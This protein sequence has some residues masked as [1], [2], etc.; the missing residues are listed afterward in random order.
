MENKSNKTF[1]LS[2]WAIKNSTI[3]Y[4]LMGIF[5]ILGGSAYINMPRENFPEITETT[6]F[7]STPY[8][9][10]TAQDVERFVTDPIE[11]GIKGISNIVEI[12]S[13]SQDD[14]SIV[15]IEFD[16]DIPVDLAKQKVKDEVDAVKA[17]EDWPTFNNAKL[18]PSVFNLNFS[19]EM[20]ILNV[21]IQ[22]DYPI[23]RLKAYGEI[24][25]DRIEQ[26]EQIKAVDIRGAQDKEVEIAVDI[27]KMMASQISFNDVVQS[28]ANENTTI[29][30]GSM[31]GAGQ[32]RSIRVVGEIASP[33][34][35]EAFVVSNE[36]GTVSL[37][38]IAT[39]ALKDQETTS[40]ARDFG[41]STVMLDVKK[42]GG[43]NLIQAAASIREIVLDAKANDF[44]E[45]LTVTISNDMSSLTLNQVNDLVN[46]I[47]FGVLLVVT[48]L[49]F[50]LGF[51]NALFVGFAI[52]MSMFIS[53]VILQTLGYTM[54][55]MVLF[56]LVMG[57]GMLVD[58][59]IVVVEN[60]YRLIEKEGLSRVEA[61]KKGVSEIAYP[62]IIS[63]ATTVAAFVP[64][65]FWPGIMGQF[66]IY[67]PITLSIVLGSSLFVA[68]LFNSM[69]VS[70]F[71]DVEEKNLSKK[72]LIRLSLVLG[73]I[74]SFFMVISSSTRGFGSFLITLMAF[75]W[76]YRYFIKGLANTFQQFFLNKLERG[77]EKVLQFA[78]RG[79]RAYAFVFGTIVLLLTSFV[80]VGVA[81]PKVEFFPDNEPSQIIVYIEYPQ[82]TDIDKTN[83][84]TKAV[85]Q[86]VI[87]T[88]NAEKYLDKGKNFMVE[89]LVSQ[90][91]AGA[92]NPQTDGGSQAEMPH[93][94][95]ITATMREYKFRRGLS[96]EV[97]RSEVQQALR[98]QFSGV[99]ISVEKDA[100]GPPVGY[101]V[102]IELKGKDY[103]EL[104]QVA[105]DVRTFIIKEN[106]PGIEELKVDV[107]RNKPGMEVVVDRRKAGSL[108][109]SAGQVGFQLRRA[110][111]GEKAG[112]FKK[113]GEDY[114]INVRFQE[115]DRYDASALFN[116]N[117]TFRDMA[118]GRIKN[119]P[120][121][122][123]VETKNV[124]GYSAIKHKNL[125]RVV[126]VYSAILP[127]YNA[128]QIV[129]QIQTQMQGF[130]M[131]DGITY[132][133][134]G[135]IAEQEENMRFLSS[136]LGFAILLIMLLLVFQFNSVS[137]PL[138]ILFS[139][140]MSFTGVMLGLVFFNMTFVII[141]TMMGIISLAGI[142]VNNSVVLL[143]YTQLLLDRKREE[144]KIASE[145]LLPKKDIFDAIVTGG[146]AR[147]RPVLLTA[148][149]TVLGLIPLA[150]G[151]NI[152][153]FSLF[154]TGNPQLYFGGENVIFWGPLAWTVIFGL[155]FATF[156]TLIIV[157]VTFY[158][159][160][161]A[162]IRFKKW[163]GNKS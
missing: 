7:I 119:I 113:D 112:V 97:L 80:L 157:P 6:I 72:G 110:L 140:F 79:W 133:F 85:E 142:V 125:R 9:G 66:M 126:T 42:R 111:F 30:A 54:N 40:F 13:T 60:V 62:I 12:T 156:L 17:S 81:G 152:N 2:D 95:K 107:N 102:N 136:A 22:G 159:S 86:L 28:I 53:F 83:K 129:A 123:V 78:L 25:E 89:S 135:E 145:D 43:K 99:R 34:Q 94:G 48:V 11:E 20:P 148:I 49:T 144:L 117:I 91:G 41:T 124:A 32:R 21:S 27:R 150:I 84:I 109:V 69:L 16:E 90:V 130:E 1:G 153:F 76:L 50:F 55:T 127:G 103:D 73:S 58:N 46:N 93:R 131:P 139:I 88:V 64:L 3:I 106:I 65:G 68:L 118:S 36:K 74:G 96:S 120:I 82:G 134:T 26:L 132:A 47:L 101:P 33:K 77:Y 115:S 31:R 146:K 121:S 138:I 161:R 143:D 52:P 38:E 105:N 56:A 10:N 151:L 141:M 35:L 100:N 116:Q 19:E 122:A 4:V 23:D 51:R 44:P 149:T 154:A 71:M 163:R 63:T 98:G 57:L 104:I 162:A 39:I 14:Y 158:L 61:A 29:S 92:G 155:T 67:F 147:L 87:K 70:K 37:G 5:L 18:E 24:L 160:K 108:G 128:N 75:F 59:G 15:S 8:P 45:D 114:D 137:K